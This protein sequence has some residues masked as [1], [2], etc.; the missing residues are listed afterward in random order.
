MFWQLFLLALSTL[1]ELPRFTESTKMEV[2]LDR[3]EQTIGFQLINASSVRVRKFNRAV[4]VLDGTA[5][6]FQDLGDDYDIQLRAAYSTMGNQQFN[7]YPMKIGRQGMCKGLNGP[8]K[9]YQSLFL[10]WTNLPA[11]GNDWYCPLKKMIIEVRNWAPKA[12]WV[13]DV[14][15]VGYWKITCD[16]FGPNKELA[17]QVSAYMRIKPKMF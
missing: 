15:P 2:E 3:F 17:Y 11:I 5:E 6:V 1:V 4:S 13:P 10:N 12:S 7:E 9:E 16:I 8:Y 14:V